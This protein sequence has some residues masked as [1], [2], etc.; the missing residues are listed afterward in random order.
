MCSPLLIRHPKSYCWQAGRQQGRSQAQLLSAT[1]PIPPVLLQPCP[2]P[3]AEHCPTYSSTQP[4]SSLPFGICYLPILLLFLRVLSN[5]GTSRCSFNP[6]YLSDFLSQRSE[7]RLHSCAI[8]EPGHRS[9]AQRQPNF[10]VGCLQQRLWRETSTLV[11][12]TH[13]SRCEKNNSHR[14]CQQQEC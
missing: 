9:A 14:S 4:P 10:W 11:S 13:I 12:T 3:L 5:S 2:Q 8:S 6:S 1:S 7:S